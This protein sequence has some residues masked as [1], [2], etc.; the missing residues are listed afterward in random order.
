ML[1]LLASSGGPVVNSH[2]C[3]MVDHPCMLWVHLDD[4]SVPLDSFRSLQTARVALAWM[5][6]LPHALDFAAVVPDYR[7]LGLASDHQA[8]L[9]AR[10]FI[11]AHGGA[12]GNPHWGKF[13]MAVMGEKLVSA[14]EEAM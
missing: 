2:R 11:H 9:R 1:E 14:N 8:C 10:S 5:P 6:T 3:A 13:W 7:I 12:I 4:H